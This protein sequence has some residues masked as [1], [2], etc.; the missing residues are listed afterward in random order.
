MSLLDHYFIGK[1]GWTFLQF[2]LLTIL[3][4]TVENL[5]RL[6][7]L[8]KHVETPAMLLV[9]LMAALLPEYLAIGLFFALYLGIGLTVRGMAQRG[10]WTIMAAS[11]VSPARRMAMPLLLGLGAAIL[12]LSVR[13]ELQPRGERWL[14]EIGSAVSKGEMGVTFDIGDIIPLPGGGMV[15][16]DSFDRSTRMAEGVFLRNG[17]LIATA[18]AAQFTHDDGERIRM[19]L[20]GGEAMRDGQ[21]AVHFDRMQLIFDRDSAADANRAKPMPDKLDRLPTAALLGRM[22]DEVSAGQIER[23]ALAALLA[24]LANALFCLLI[25]VLAV[26]L[27]ELP[28]RKTSGFALGLGMIA[29][30]GFIRGLSAVE[31]GFANA[32][33]LAMSLY[34]AAWAATAALLYRYAKASIGGAEAA[35]SH[36]LAG[37][38]DQIIRLLRLRSPA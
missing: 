7:D 3:L 21:P 5:T 2:L 22:A 12:L 19:V 18:R 13:L 38:F 14:D 10:E 33:L 31:H 32:P 25:P 26:A 16:I 27:S 36:W 15:T 35:V 20:Y 29:I 9:K 23:P 17:G 6:L 11:G 28:P 37:P 34:F 8:I 30:V 24:R 4:L 1:A